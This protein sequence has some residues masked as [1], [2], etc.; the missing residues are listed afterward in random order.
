MTKEQNQIITFF[1]CVR[2]VYQVKGMGRAKAAKKAYKALLEIH[3]EEYL[4][5]LF[6]D[7]IEAQ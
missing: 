2:A 1:H 5:E 3:S 4:E 7:E 6:K